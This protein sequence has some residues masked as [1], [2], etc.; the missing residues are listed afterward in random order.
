MYEE[1]HLLVVAN[2]VLTRRRNER[3]DVSILYLAPNPDAETNAVKMIYHRLSNP[4]VWVRD[5]CLSE[6]TGISTPLGHAHL[7]DLQKREQ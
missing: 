3:Q 1:E 6:F 4:T 2:R 7:S 5:P